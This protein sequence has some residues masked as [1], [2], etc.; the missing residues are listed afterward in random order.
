M[1]A[2][3]HF[4]PVAAAG[5]FRCGCH[6]DIAKR[7][8]PF[9]DIQVTSPI[10][11]KYAYRFGIAAGS[12]NGKRAF[13]P[14]AKPCV[15]ADMADDFAE[16]I[17]SCPSSGEGTQPAVAHAADCS[18]RCIVNGIVCQGSGTANG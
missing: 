4:E 12:P 6:A 16:G 18:A 11:K 7:P 10:L 2:G 17:R 14:D 8:I 3:T 13:G 1:S 5:V 9:C 15:A